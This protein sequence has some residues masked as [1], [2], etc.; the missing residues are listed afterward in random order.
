MSGNSTLFRQSAVTAVDRSSLLKGSGKPV[1][2]PSRPRS[3]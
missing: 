2:F 1:A 3:Q